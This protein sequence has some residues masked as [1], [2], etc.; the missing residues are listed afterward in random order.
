MQECLL[1]AF[2]LVYLSAYSSTLTI[3]AICSS[4]RFVDFKRTTRY[5]IPEDSIFQKIPLFSA[6]GLYM[7]SLK[8]NTSDIQRTP[9]VDICFNH[10]EQEETAFRFEHRGCH[11]HIIVAINLRKH[12][13]S[14]PNK[15]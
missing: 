3:E 8:W 13:T 12:V 14:F 2:M 9:S 11:M 6:R 10:Q 4:E 15:M 7:L 5:Y 1:L